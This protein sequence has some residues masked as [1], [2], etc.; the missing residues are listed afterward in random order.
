M[1]A[2]LHRRLAN[3]AAAIEDYDRALALVTNAAERRYLADARDRVADLSP[4]IPGKNHLAETWVTN[5][6]KGS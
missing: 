1:R 5:Q 4:T 3:H 6:E 2:D